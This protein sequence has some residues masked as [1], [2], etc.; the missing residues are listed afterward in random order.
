[1]IKQHS[2]TNVSEIITAIQTYIE[3]TAETKLLVEPTVKLHSDS[4][5]VETADEVSHEM[6]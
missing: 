5:T 4:A 2:S 6:S 1:M 3:S